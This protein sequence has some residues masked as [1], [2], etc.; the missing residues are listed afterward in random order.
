MI[1]K[2]GMTLMEILV[3]IGILVILVLVAIPAYRV[4]QQSTKLN[5]DARALLGDLRLAQQNTVAEQKTYLVKIYSNPDRYEV[6][7]REASDTVIKGRDLS[8]DVAWQN[9]GGFTN[10]EVVFTTSGAV[11]ESGII[12]LYNEV[13]NKTVSVEVKP[14]GYVQIN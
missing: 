10:N 8:L 11:V 12:V 4:G 7:R 1:R 2:V 14:S 6:V 3:A 5:G 13:S 9:T